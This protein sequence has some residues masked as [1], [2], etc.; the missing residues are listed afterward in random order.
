MRDVDAKAY[1]ADVVQRSGS[2]FVSAMRIL[3]PAKRD[4]MYAVYAFC[5]EVDDI[6][7]AR[8]READKRAKL[9]EWRA[10][11]DR[12]Y[13]GRPESPVGRALLGPVRVFGLKRETF[14]AVIE[15]MEID[16]AEKL[17]LP[18]MAALEAYCD[19]VACA[20]GRLSNP[21]FGVEDRLGEPVAVA[22]GQALQL[23]NILR[24]LAEDAALNRLYLPHDLLMRFD[25][26]D[27]DA[28]AAIAHARFPE[29]CDELATL[30]AR[31]F[32]EAEAALARCD[33]RIMRPAIMM[34]AVYRAILHKLRRRG[35]RRLDEAVSLGTAEKLWILLRYG[36]L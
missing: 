18:D 21:V 17:R 24:D 16:S 22:L 5:R 8:G 7:D 29:A 10:E 30:A 12:L 2:S 34:M 4:G 27:N 36:L 14:L 19:K 13:E 28:P 11:I 35:W 3:P 33:R 25:I 23:T 9:S 26:P 31:R 32:A 6:A 20:V 1:V 15:G